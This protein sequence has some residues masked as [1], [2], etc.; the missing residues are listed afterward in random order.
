MGRQ[1]HKALPTE[2]QY[3]QP[4]VD[5]IA[6]LSPDDLNEDIDPAPLEALMLARIEGMEVGQANTLLKN[7]AQSLMSWLQKENLDEHPAHWVFAF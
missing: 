3:L 1:K 2:L 6:K 7:D 4:F 5:S